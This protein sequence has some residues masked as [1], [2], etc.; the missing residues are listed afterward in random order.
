M[1]Y[2]LKDEMVTGTSTYNCAL[3]VASPRLAIIVGYA[4]SILQMV[5]GRASNST[6]KRLKV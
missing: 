3:Q 5:D 6:K 2:D 4:S 1:C